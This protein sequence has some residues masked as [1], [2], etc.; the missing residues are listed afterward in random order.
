MQNARNFIRAYALAYPSLID[1]GART[2]INYGVSGVP[3]TFFIDREGI[4]RSVDRGGLTTAP[5]SE[6]L[7]RIEINWP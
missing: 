7:R 5:L 3:E 1:L 6:G 4:V 2:A